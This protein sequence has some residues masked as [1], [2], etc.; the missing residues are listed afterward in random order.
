MC[1]VLFDTGLLK[2]KC[3][4]C[5]QDAA[6]KFFPS[7][8]A[9]VLVCP[10]HGRSSPVQ[11]TLF[12]EEGIASIPKFL[13]VLTCFLLNIPSNAICQLSGTREETVGSSIRVKMCD[14]NEEDIGNRV[15]LGGEGKVV[16]IDEVF[17]ATHK[18]HR[19]TPRSKQ[20]VWVFGMMEVDAAEKV[21]NDQDLLM[22]I[23]EKERREES[24]RE[25]EEER[26]KVQATSREK[27]SNTTSLSPFHNHQ[28][29]HERR[30]RKKSNCSNP[31]PSK[32]DDTGRE[33]QETKSEVSE[34]SC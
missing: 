18:H 24:T 6:T 1:Q 4:T 30:A 19:G 3:P 28:F 25:E 26:N 20:G 33:R 2:A 12:E 16:E 22:F 31:S 23:Q 14:K 17:L 29:H 9:P 13:F 34:P 5:G 7:R 32:K 21:V 10:Q 8:P 11:H 15:V 27:N